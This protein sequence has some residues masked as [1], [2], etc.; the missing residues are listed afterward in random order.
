LS[1]VVHGKELADYQGV[2]ALF[3]GDASVVSLPPNRAA[4]LRELLP[5]RPM[6]LSPDDLALALAPLTQNVVGPAFIGYATQ[7]PPASLPVR[8]LGPN[9]AAARQELEAACLPLEWEHGGNAVEHPSSGVFIDGRLAA[10][11][12]YEVWGGTIAHIAIIT[13]PAFRKCGYA[14]S[15]VAHLAR[16]ALSVGLLPQYHTLQANTA[17]IGIARSLG[18]ASFA[19]SIAIRLKAEV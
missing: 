10:L 16:R 9:D 12:G 7:V 15:A 14:R 19:R 17:S 6:F 3:H 8:T 11:A 2:F 18:F 13:H 5:D 4:D 1:I